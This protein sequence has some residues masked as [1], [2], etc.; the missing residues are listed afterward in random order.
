LKWPD[1]TQAFT[2]DLVLEP[3]ARL[4]PAKRAVSVA[5]RCG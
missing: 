5:G 1:E 4:H 3:S 2:I